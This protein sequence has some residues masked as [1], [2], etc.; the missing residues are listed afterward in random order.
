MK[1]NR[2]ADVHGVVNVC[3]SVFLLIKLCQFSDDNRDNRDNMSA[4]LCNINVVSVVP[5]VVKGS[6]GWSQLM[7]RYVLENGEAFAACLVRGNSL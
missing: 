7:A 3:Q 4:P 6:P 2:L 5:V 1:K